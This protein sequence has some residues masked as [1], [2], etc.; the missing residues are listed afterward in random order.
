MKAG[1][2]SYQERNIK[3]EALKYSDDFEVIEICMP[4]DFP[5]Q[6]AQR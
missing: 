6:D 5:T 2:R 1:L 3:H 4:A